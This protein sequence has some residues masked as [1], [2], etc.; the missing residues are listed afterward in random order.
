MFRKL[1]ERV[2]RMRNLTT[3]V[4]ACAILL[5]CSTPCPQCRCLTV[6]EEEPI[7]LTVPYTLE[8]EDGIR[9]EVVPAEAGSNILSCYR[10]DPDFE[11]CSRR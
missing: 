11:R 4:V 2:K 6:G 1:M 10:E 9:C 7:G 5:A 8:I 3:L